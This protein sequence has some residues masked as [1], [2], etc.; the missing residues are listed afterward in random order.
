MSYRVLWD[1]VRPEPA[2]LIRPTSLSLP[3][4]CWSAQV[5]PCNGHHR[6]P[7]IFP[8]CAGPGPWSGQGTWAGISRPSSN[9]AGYDALIVEGKA[10]TPV[11]LM[12]RD[13]HGN[14]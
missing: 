8:T 10:D 9:H 6:K 7:T 3:P 14:T 12:I 13:A 1:E 4:A 5:L 2:P 11:W